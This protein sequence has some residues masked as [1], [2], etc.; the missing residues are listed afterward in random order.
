MPTELSKIKLGGNTYNIKDTT[1]RSNVGYTIIDGTLY[2]DLD[3]LNGSYDPASGNV[4]LTREDSHKHQFLKIEPYQSPLDIISIFK[5]SVLDNIR[6]TISNGFFEVYQDKINNNIWN[7]HISLFIEDAI[8]MRTLTQLFNYGNQQYAFSGSYVGRII[9]DG[10]QYISSINFNNLG[11]RTEIED[12]SF[13]KFLY[14]CPTN[15]DEAD[16]TT[17]MSIEI[18]YRTEVKDKLY[19]FLTDE[20]LRIKIYME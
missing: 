16:Q 7:F 17:R 4:L 15:S 10:A 11:I 19:E 12:G 9:N 6:A 1:A 8:S 14:R 20:N 5:G 3:T 13:I 2:Q 18:L